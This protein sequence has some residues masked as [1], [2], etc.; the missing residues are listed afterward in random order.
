MVRESTL[1][2]MIDLASSP[3]AGSD[4]PST[5]RTSCS[6]TGP[7]GVIV[8][9]PSGAVNGE[10]RSRSDGKLAATLVVE[11]PEIEEDAVGI[12]IQTDAGV[13]ITV[14]FEV[15][16]GGENVRRHGNFRHRPREHLGEGNAARRSRCWRFDYRRGPS[17]GRDGET[18]LA[19][20]SAYIVRHDGS[21]IGLDGNV[22]RDWRVPHR[23]GSKPSPAKARSARSARSA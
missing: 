11:R 17:I 23:V 9:P 2:G 8:I 1:K 7:R 6:R 10:Y 18:P 19:A 13:G 15:I 16:G 4:Q 22:R 14:G 5:V 21:R 12:A 3:L 20:I